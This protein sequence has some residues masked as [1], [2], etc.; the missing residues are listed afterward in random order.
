MV[1]KGGDTQVSHYRSEK[2]V[3]LGPEH[4]QVKPG[5]QTT[6]VKAS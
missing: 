6:L 4:C 5:L 3:L 1:G 2:T